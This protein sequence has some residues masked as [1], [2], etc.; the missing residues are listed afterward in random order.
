MT[1]S[2]NRSRDAAKSA[3][4]SERRSTRARFVPPASISRGLIERLGGRYS[5]ALGID[6]DAGDGEVERWFLASTLF[7]TRIAAQIAGKTFTV[8]SAAGVNRIGDVA[9]RSWGDLVALLDAGGYSRY[10]FKTATRLQLLAEEVAQRYGNVAAIG[11]RYSAPDEL[12]AALDALP[13]WGPVTV[14]LFL[15]ELRGVW[16]GAR[17]SID[18]RAAAMVN[19]LGLLDRRGRDD[20]TA[21]QELAEQAGCDIRDLEAALVRLDLA[22][23]RTPD[24]AGG[25][26]C[27]FIGT[28]PQPG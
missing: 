18:R 19:H 3:G 2:A 20:W 22:H 23:R 13:G 7:G 11:R 28:A 4:G 26:A 5:R 27:S 10:D 6:V 16:E 8:F 21:L 14:S 1:R 17:L 9:S 24:C 12:V 25:S 15:R